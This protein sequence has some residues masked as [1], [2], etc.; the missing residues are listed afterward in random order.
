MALALLDPPWTATGCWKP[1]VCQQGWQG[2]PRDAASAC[3]APS[4]N[5]ENIKA[6]NA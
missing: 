2:L 5:M 1:V 3:N 6:I 4:G